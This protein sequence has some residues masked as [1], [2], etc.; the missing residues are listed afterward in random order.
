MNLTNLITSA[1][2]DVFKTK[3]LINEYMQDIYKHK[4]KLLVLWNWSGNAEQLVVKEKW[5]TKRR[6]KPTKLKDEK[7]RKNSRNDAFG[8]KR[9]RT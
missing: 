7:S 4:Q 5:K 9:R 3:K 2:V 6:G 1:K 8:E